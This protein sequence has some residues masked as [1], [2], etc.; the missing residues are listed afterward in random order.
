MEWHN[1]GGYKSTAQLDRL[2]NGVVSKICIFSVDNN[3]EGSHKVGSNLFCIS[4]DVKTF[5]NEVFCK[6]KACLLYL[7]TA[8]KLVN[9]V[10]SNIMVWHMAV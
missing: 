8:N 9:T 6:K 5:C 3:G 4:T 2:P 10:V 1:Q 7:I